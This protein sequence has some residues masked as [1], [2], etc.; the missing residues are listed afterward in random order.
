MKT[1][2]TTVTLLALSVASVVAKVNWTFGFF[3][4]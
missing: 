1:R 2:L 4:G 3:Q